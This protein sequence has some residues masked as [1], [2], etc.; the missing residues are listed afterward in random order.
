MHTD[1]LLLGL[2]DAELGWNL[3]SGAVSVVYAI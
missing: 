3:V 2:D 1:Y